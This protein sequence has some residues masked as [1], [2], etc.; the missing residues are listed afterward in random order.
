MFD[1][2]E[3]RI[4]SGFDSGTNDRENR[5]IAQRHPDR[6]RFELFLQ[7]ESLPEGTWHSITSIGVVDSL[8]DLEFG[9]LDD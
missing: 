7:E 3:T 8:D 9:D 1:E 4:L 6:D 2:P 5:V